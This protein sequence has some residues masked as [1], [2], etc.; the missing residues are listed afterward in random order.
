[1]YTNKKDNVESKKEN[2]KFDDEVEELKKTNEEME[3]E[4]SENSNMLNGNNKERNLAISFVSIGGCIYVLSQDYSLY[5]ILRFTSLAFLSLGLLLFFKSFFKFIS[6]KEE[7][8]DVSKFSDVDDKFKKESE[9]SESVLQ[10]KLNFLLERIHDLEINRTNNV[11]EYKAKKEDLYSFSSYFHSIR[12]LLEQKSNMADK[13]ASILLDKGT[14]YTKL[15]IV[16][17]ITSIVIWQ[18]LFLVFGYRTNFLWGI[19]S[20]SFVFIFIEFLS[21]WFLKQ[22]KSFTDTSTYLIKVKSI[23][24]RYMMLYLIYDDDLMMDDS[25]KIA[26]SKLMDTIVNDVNWPEE[27]SNVRDESFAKE[28]IEAITSLVDK[29]KGKDK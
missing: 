27:S 1:M 19:L 13:K 2:I 14:T 15:G 29:I 22:Y 10:E 11:E 4:K 12:N 6:L 3:K 28:T 26:L 17:Y 18:I 20:C 24:D 16:F 5:S 23:F 8:I 21:A 25:K 7:S 9:L